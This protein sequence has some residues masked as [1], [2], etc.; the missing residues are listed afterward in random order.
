M[1]NGNA[2]NTQ[3]SAITFNRSAAAN[4]FINN[5]GGSLDLGGSSS[6]GSLTVTSSGGTTINNN[7]LN[8]GSG[9]FDLITSALNL[10]QNLS[11]T[12]VTLN[13]NGAITGA[14]QLVAN[15]LNF[16]GAGNI[17]TAGR[18]LSVNAAKIVFNQTGGT[19]FITQ[20][21]SSATDL[22][23]D[24]GGD[25]TLNAGATTIGSSPLRINNGNGNVTFNVSS[26]NLHSELLAHNV[27][28]HNSGA[29]TGGALINSATLSLI[30]AG[31]VGSPAASINTS[32]GTVS[33]NKTGGGAFVNDTSSGG[34][35]LQGTTTG[36][37]TVNSASSIESTSLAVTGG[38]SLSAVD[39]ISLSSSGV[40]LGP[41]RIG[42]SA[43]TGAAEV[44]LGG[45]GSSMSLQGGIINASEVRLG[46][47]TIDPG[48][49]LSVITPNF[50]GLPGASAPNGDLEEA[51]P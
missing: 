15:T 37:L 31:G 8:L 26:L 20:S 12:V 36:S 27:V 18:G 33:L 9:N 1:G 34:V 45:T 7:A 46:N 19:D 39:N 13:Y 29:V 14:G 4:D 3:T 49:K 48:F 32:A 35:T 41:L 47:V 11:G 6:G 50:G 38:T 23:G 30:G 42:D 17:G 40:V 25:L 28:I 51:P 5:T 43:T 24:T 44:T 2:L 16:D 21:A 10:G 22:S